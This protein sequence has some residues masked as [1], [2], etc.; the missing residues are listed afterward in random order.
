MK[1]KVL[2]CRYCRAAFLLILMNGRFQPQGAGRTVIGFTNRDRLDW[3]D[4]GSSF[5]KL[6]IN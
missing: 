3:A 2:W 1:P 6:V 5:F 4:S